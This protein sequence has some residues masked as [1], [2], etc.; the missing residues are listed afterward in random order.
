MRAGIRVLQLQIGDRR[1]L[2]LDGRQRTESRRQ[3]VEPVGSGGVQRVTSHAHRH[4]HKPSRRSRR[5]SPGVLASAVI[6]GIIA[7]SK[8]NARVVPTPRR[9]N[10]RGKDF[11]VI[12]IRISSSETVCWWRSPESTTRTR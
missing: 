12:I 1:D 9:N 3:L 11:F 5:G 8:G 6:E 4:I 2:V 7:S 10:R